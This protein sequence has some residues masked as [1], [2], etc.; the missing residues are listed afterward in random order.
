MHRGITCSSLLVLVLASCSEGHDRSEDTLP[1]LD[2]GS[3]TADAG[4]E[5][6]DAA[7]EERDAPCPPGFA[8]CEGACVNTRES[9][10]YCG[11]DARCEGFVRCLG[12]EACI[13]G[14]CQLE[15]E[16]GLT[17]CEGY[18]VRPSDD[19]QH[20][21]A[22]LDGCRG[23]ARCEPGELCARG[24][25]VDACP[26]GSFECFGRCID[27]LSDPQYCGVGA[28]CSGGDGT[29]FAGQVCSGGACVAA[30][31]ADRI[32]CAG[33][34]VDPRTDPTYCGAETDCSGGSVCGSAEVCVEGA[35]ASACPAPSIACGGRC[36]EPASDRSFCGAGPD[37]AGGELCTA[38]LECRAGVCVP[39][40]A[41]PQVLCESRCVDPRTDVTHCGAD[42]S[43]A[44][45][46]TC[47]VREVCSA[48][49]CACALGEEDCGSGCVDVR[50][51]ARHCGTCERVCATGERCLD[52]DCR[53]DGGLTGGFGS[54]WESFP[55]TE[56]L[57]LQEYLPRGETDL[58]AG[59]GARFGA[60]ETGALRFR[61]AAAPPLAIARHTSFAHYGGG[62]F[63][64]AATDLVFY[65]PPT[66]EWR[67]ASLGSDLGEVGMTISE[68]DSLWTA[69]AGALHRGAPATSTIATIPTPTRLTAP[70]LTFEALSQRVIF[71]SQGERELRSYDL[72]T[73]T[74]RVE[75]LAPDA[76]GVAFCGDRDGHVYVG[77]QAEP[78]RLWQYTAASGSWVELPLLPVSVMGTTNCGV[79]ETGALYVASAPGA[80][81]HRLALERR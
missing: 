63:Q 11:A 49:L 27:P 35:C 61:A 6:L 14:L 50:F 2:A 38:G 41:A 78:R 74:F 9:P 10:A 46:V 42:A 8:L 64:I 18:C 24:A 65:Q 19:P 39:T 28:S 66:D 56:V 13:E 77:S 71:A 44:G 5:T 20:C 52:G 21:G 75:A 43:C 54:A 29:C 23:G 15:C 3:G 12:N 33:R 72:V 26:P 69:S 36:V 67:I 60:W 4:S 17:N 51:D 40:C 57:A 79:A 73:R 16:P 34:C 1:G 48:G 81:L 31:P 30:C 25:C 62:I 59:T 76:I 37:C 53:V 80:E 68:G 22:S 45:G 58:Y 47:G 70:R 55:F 7:P 32:P